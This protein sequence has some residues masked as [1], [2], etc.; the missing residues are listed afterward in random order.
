MMKETLIPFYWKLLQYSG[1]YPDILLSQSLRGKAKH[2]WME[3][4]KGD[5]FNYNIHIF[6]SVL[7]AKGPKRLTLC[8]C[9]THLSESFPRWHDW[10]GIYN[11]NTARRR[12]QMEIS[13]WMFSSPP[14]WPFLSFLDASQ[15]AHVPVCLMRQGD[16]LRELQLFHH[17]IPVVKQEHSQ[18]L[19]RHFA[20]NII[21]PLGCLYME[22]DP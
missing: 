7:L 22:R 15:A 17:L 2:S 6:L 8:Y 20:L 11:T 9:N 1:G 12:L 10:G 18:V 14:P 21:P 13:K 5:F 19:R 16:V 4:E 3:E